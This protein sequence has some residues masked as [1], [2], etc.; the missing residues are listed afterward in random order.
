MQNPV[1]NLFKRL[2]CA[3]VS[4]SVKYKSKNDDQTNVTIRE[5]TDFVL[6]NKATL[7]YH[8]CNYLI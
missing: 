1:Y 7:S 5:S 4:Q 3:F 8:I 6:S 2:K